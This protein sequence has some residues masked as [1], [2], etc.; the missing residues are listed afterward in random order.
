MLNFVFIGGLRLQRQPDE[1]GQFL[2]QPLAERRD[3]PGEPGGVKWLDG[4][5]AAGEALR[6]FPPRARFFWRWRLGMV[7]S[8]MGR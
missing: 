4:Q 8:I 6:L 1:P 3:L 7:V 5:I 2:L